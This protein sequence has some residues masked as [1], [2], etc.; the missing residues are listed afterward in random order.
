[1]VVWKRR[2]EQQFCRTATLVESRLLGRLPQA[3]G[4]RS[5][6]LKSLSRRDDKLVMA[7]RRRWGAD[8]VRR[9]WEGAH[10][11]MSDS[12]WDAFRAG[13]PLHPILE[14]P[15][16]VVEDA[17]RRNLTLKGVVDEL[18]RTHPLPPPKPIIEPPPSVVMF[19]VYRPT[20]AIPEEEPEVA[21]ES[22]LVTFSPVCAGGGYIYDN[23][24]WD[25]HLIAP[26][27]LIRPNVKPAEGDLVVLVP[28]GS[29]PWC[30]VYNNFG[31]PLRLEVDMEDITVRWDW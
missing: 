23:M 9:L 7:L 10:G 30:G 1:M 6:V 27:R 17:L 8:D 21:I 31:P 24:F 2:V 4:Q 13:H 15:Q 26:A 11:A 25:K 18:D 5:P 28:A 22:R 3:P 19:T 29:R 14:R 20:P 16:S 12:E